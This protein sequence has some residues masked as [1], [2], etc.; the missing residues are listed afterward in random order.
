M[1]S[2]RGPI[3]VLL[4]LAAAAPSQVVINEFHTGSP[5]W[6]EL[7]NVSGV[8]FDLGGWSVTTYQS[9]S[10]M[11]VLEGTFT[12]PFAT[13]VPSGG[14]LVLQEYGASGAPGTLPCSIS[15]G[16]NYSW[17]SV[18]SVEVILRSPQ[19]TAV[20]Y[21]Y[22]QGAGGPIA[23][24]HLPIGATWTGLFSLSGD[25][26]ARV[27]NQ[28]TD[29]AS[30]WAIASAT[31]C[32]PNP[33]QGASQSVGLSVTTSGAGDVSVVIQTTPA[34][35]GAEFVTL[36]STV[37]LVPNGSGPVLGLA[38]DALGSIHPAQ[39]GSPFHGWLD[40]Q[41]SLVFAAPVGSVPPGL[42]IEAVVAML[43][44]TGQLLASQVVEITF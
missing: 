17:T 28:D 40:P 24:P 15:T 37:D 23:P 22:R 9:G 39:P 30:D 25:G 41:G 32:A 43:A 16:S 10:G 19:Q 2:A 4:A 42:H 13:L 31:A 29:A 12:I 33:G 34:I 44:P 5:D 1:T 14:F 3:L 20:D 18:R 26:C 21:V 36:T 38:W 11:P 6:V 35:P 27:S 7:R 8:P